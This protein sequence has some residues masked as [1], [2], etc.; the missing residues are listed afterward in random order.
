MLD[1]SDN[2]TSPGFSKRWDSHDKYTSV[3]FALPGPLDS[4]GPTS[5]T[6]FSPGIDKSRAG[7]SSLA[8]T[9][10]R[11]CVGECCSLTA[12][13]MLDY[14]DNQTSPGFSKRWDSHDK[15]T[16]VP[17]ANSTS[18]YLHSPSSILLLRI[19][20]DHVG[21]CPPPNSP[22]AKR[23]RSSQS[24]SWDC[25]HKHDSS[26]K[27]SCGLRS[28][29][30]EASA[31]LSLLKEEQFDANIVNFCRVVPW[32]CDVNH[33]VLSALKIKVRKWM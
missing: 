6:T 22:P 4:L 16:S 28:S 10:L 11:D 15:Y 29:S 23:H 19:D 1:Y 20:R 26:L 7:S 3:P 12:A 17:S 9:A 31:V 14:S 27:L 24:L 5:L 25:K 32:I 21:K 18:R 13:F 8:K 30:E 33:L 2:Q